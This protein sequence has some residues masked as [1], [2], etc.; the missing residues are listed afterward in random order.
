M[1]DPIGLLQ[2]LIGLVGRQDLSL[3]FLQQSDQRIEAGPQ[4]GNL[5]G[6]QTDGPGQLFLR[7][8]PSAA[9]HQPVFERSGDHIRAVA[10]SD[11][12]TLGIVL[13]VGVNHATDRE[14]LLGQIS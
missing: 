2:D 7:Q 11:W 14:T 6:I 8:S 4:T 12:E 3:S 10:A 13:L 9:V 5:T 1:V